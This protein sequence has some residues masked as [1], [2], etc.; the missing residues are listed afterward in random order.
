MHESLRPKRSAKFPSRYATNC[1]SRRPE[2]HARDR[3][4]AQIKAIQMKSVPVGRLDCEPAGFASPAARKPSARAL[5]PAGSHNATT[6]TADREYGE[7]IWRSVFSP[8]TS[9]SVA[10][11]RHRS[12]CAAE[13]RTA[14]RHR[15]E[16]HAQRQV[17]SLRSVWRW[18]KWTRSFLGRREPRPPTR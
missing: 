7:R 17:A 18:P 6:Q 1:K 2:L 13:G 3:K 14:P 11:T 15:C 10:Q 12:E 4:T 5:L 9:G 8:V 16:P